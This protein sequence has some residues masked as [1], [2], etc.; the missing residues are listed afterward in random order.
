MDYKLYFGLDTGEGFTLPVLPEE[1]EVKKDGN[2]ETIN[3]VNLGEVSIINK[4]KLADIE[5]ECHFP[6]HEAP[7]LATDKLMPPSYYVKK[8]EKWRDEEKPIR[9]ILVGSPLEINQLYSIEN[10][11]KKEVGGEVGDI[12][13]LI[14][15][16]EYAAG[17]VK[18][19][20]IVNTSSDKK[21]TSKPKPSRPNTSKPKVKTHTVRKGD[22]LWG[23]SKRYL[24]KGSRFD[25]IAKL[26]N[27]K[28]PNIIRVGQI[29]KI[30]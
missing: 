2:N 3:I 8:I 21:A 27:I 18:K 23:I 1:I 5:F 29:I 24:G 4:P 9:V 30:P 6:L 25:E 16:K 11:N 12:Y 22:T 19:V 14:H 13:Y 28:N 7:Y 10:F 20:K 26:N 15:L 17:V